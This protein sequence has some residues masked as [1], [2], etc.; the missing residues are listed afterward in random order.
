M[1]KTLLEMSNLQQV[2]RN[3]QIQIAP[4]VEEIFTDLAPLAEKADI[5]LELDGDGAMTGSDALIYRL[6]FNLTENAIKYNRPGGS[7][8]VSVSRAGKAAA[9]TRLRH[10]LRHTRRSISGAYSSPSSAWTSPVAAS[11]AA[12]G[13]GSRWYGR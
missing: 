12:R 8:R 11:T 2:A 1:T 13:W 10:R 4:M 9:Y 7:V 5:A 6:I 3:E